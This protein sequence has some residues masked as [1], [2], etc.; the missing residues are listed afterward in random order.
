MT[1]LILTRGLP[2]S[3]KSTWAKQW[4]LEDHGRRVRLNRDDLRQSFFVTPSYKNEQ[5]TVVTLSEKETARRALKLGYDVVVDATNLRPAY[6]REWRRLAVGNGAE[7]EI[8]EFPVDLQEAIVRDSRREATVGADVI[9]KMYQR[10][11]HKGRFLPVGDDGDG[12]T[13]EKY[14]NTGTRPRC[15]IV[16]IDGTLA[17]NNSGRS[18]YDLD[19]VHEDDLN[20]PV[21]GIVDRYYHTHT[22]MV[23]SGRED[24]CRDLT[25][26]WLHHH[27]IQHDKLVMRK[28]GD[29]RKDSVVKYEIFL[30]HVAGWYDVDFVLDDRNQVVEMW[31]DVG[32]PCFQVAPGDF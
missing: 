18:P 25:E 24:S 23:F 29:R 2:A 19:R 11:L 17:L 1:K 31:R 3:G 30:E 10:Y 5:E 14:V 21:A 13:V 22:V 27:Q 26:W 7:F 6:C 32:L 16:D 28:E 8:V 20:H 12:P 9:T 4:I 15:I